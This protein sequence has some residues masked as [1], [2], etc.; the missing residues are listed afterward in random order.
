[1]SQR[2]LLKSS[3]YYWIAAHLQLA[4]LEYVLAL[5]ISEIV[6]DS[7]RTFGAGHLTP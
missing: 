6:Q 5:N 7:V 2:L 3:Y 4:M 1:M